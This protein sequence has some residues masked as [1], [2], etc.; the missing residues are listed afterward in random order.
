MNRTPKLVVLLA[1]TIVAACGER[2]VVYPELPPPPSIKSFTASKAKINLGET[3]TLSWSSEGATSA[4]LLDDAG[5]KL[6]FTGTPAEGTAEVKPER[7][8]FYVLRVKGEGGRDSAFVQVAAGEDLREVFLVAVPPEVRSGQ[9]SLLLWSAHS[10]KVAKIQ[11][12]F[13]Q[14]LPLNAEAGA[15]TLEVAPARTGVYTLVA[16]G[17][18]ASENL[19]RSQEIKVRPVVERAALSAGAAKVG[20]ALK[21]EWTTRGAGEL[22]VREATFGELGRH[23]FPGQAAQVDQGEVLFTVPAALPSGE[24]VPDGFPLRFTVQVKTA[25]PAVTL[26]R[27]LHAHVGEGPAIVQFN[28]PSAVTEGKPLAL[29][30][31]TRNAARLQLFANGALIHEPLPAD[32]GTINEGNLT[33]PPVDG[34]TT[35]ELR[36]TSHLGAQVSATRTVAR[37]ALPVI[38]SFNLPASVNAVGDAA[39]A[40]WTTQHA[41]RAFLRIKNG[42]NLAVV[43]AAQV[44]NGTLQI[45][46]G[47][48]TTVVLEAYNDAGDHVSA[49][50]TISVAGPSALS[51]D[52]SPLTTGGEVTVTWSFP[53]GLAATVYGDPLENHLKNNPSNE[54]LDL[55]LHSEAKALHFDNPL[56]GVTTLPLELPFR[57]PFVNMLAEHFFVSVNGFVSFVQP[58]PLNAP[59]ALEGNAAL[60]PMIAPFW[61]DLEL[62]AGRVL[63]VV[64]G[65]EFPRRL[66]IQWQGV[67]TSL[68]EN[69]ELTFQVQLFETGE[70]RFIY[71]TLTG[72]G[73]DGESAHVGWRTTETLARDLQV[74]G[75]FL[76]TG[77]ELVFFASGASDRTF[78]FNAER[79]GVVA[80]FVRTSAGRYI[81]FAARVNVLAPGSVLL[82]EAML[83]PEQ[84]A[85]EGLWVELANRTNADIDLSGTELGSNATETSFVVPEGTVLPANGFLVLGQSTDPLANGGAPVDLAWTVDFTIDTTATETLS[86][87]AG[88]GL[89]ASMTVDPADLV[90]GESHQAPERA[91]GVNGLGMTCARTRTFGA[92]GAV[93]TPGEANEFCFPYALETIP[94]NYR[95]ISGGNTG[96]FNP[97]FEDV[98]TQIDISAA[99]F[100]YFGQSF[101]TM[102]VCSNGWIQMGL[103]TS[104]AYTNR[105]VPS[106]TSQ[107]V[108]ALAVFWDMLEDPFWTGS[109]VYTRRIEAGED[110]SAPVGHWIVQWHRVSIFFWNDDDMNFQAK[111]FDD[112]VIEFHYD[113]MLQGFGP[114][115]GSEATIWIENLTGTGALAIGRDEPVI[116]SNLAFRFTPKL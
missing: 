2:T 61:G 25:N 16:S 65:Q 54:W 99:P 41:T 46:P 108:G 103:G 12:S 81:P 114:V 52:P 79:A 85:T 115:D 83:L 74:G 82:N 39:A 78:T 43:P 68:D 13:G 56:N 24:A 101:D 106:P 91:I 60:P 6:E 18:D 22:V 107:P 97:G 110:P 57:F 116:H 44:A 71:E 105:L 7:S 19:T 15:G 53:P 4:E 55:A 77:D 102:R 28:V 113:L 95:D 64:E 66:I 40:T 100:T 42:P 70:T 96:L 14:E 50:R 21:I 29:S 33:L 35:F 73:A 3:V 62:G 93:G 20:E 98:A 23:T 84:T 67:R 90:A 10:A 75:A 109:N 72:Q 1:A 5:N 76:A 11:T 94:V 63:W 112:G 17:V 51:A 86:L 104:T 32:V 58:G 34:E 36:A 47:Q 89:V 48:Q 59:Q 88:G 111:L 37:V 27:E 9:P 38:D 45:Y 8:T 80:P 92:N 26:D 31:V 49:E 87:T 69:S 30:W